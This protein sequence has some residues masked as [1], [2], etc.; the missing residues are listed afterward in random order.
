MMH[1][2]IITCTGR[3]PCSVEYLTRSLSDLAVKRSVTLAFSFIIELRTVSKS[4]YTIL[5][6]KPGIV[7]SQVNE[8][9]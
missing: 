8:S 9:K 1:V 6:E 2:V 5:Y 7:S 4:D 3:Q